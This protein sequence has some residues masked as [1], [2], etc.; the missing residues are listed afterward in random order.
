MTIDE[1][2]RANA[3]WLRDHEAGGNQS[4]FGRRMGASNRQQVTNW[5]GPNP[6][7]S[8][9]HETARQIERAFGRP[10]GWL[11]ERHP[12]HGAPLGST[13][14]I[15]PMQSEGRLSSLLTP[16]VEQL[17]VSQEWLRRNV[18]SRPSEHMAVTTVTGDAMRESL[19][20]GTIVL[21]DRSSSAASEDGI[22]MLG[23]QDSAGQAWFRRIAR[24]I[25]GRLHIT[26]EHPNIEPMMARTLKGSGLVVL[27]RVVVALEVRRL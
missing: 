8:I 4:E 2:R 17:G 5:I 11:D 10:V 22:Y 18:G 16:A 7:K 1:I 6:V 27:G 25:D 20:E 15:Q 26:A 3:R 21:V 19:P 9:G 14:S 13:I 23:R 24:G 12:E